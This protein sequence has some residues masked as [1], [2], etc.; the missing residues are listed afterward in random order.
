M[1]GKSI[2]NITTKCSFKLED[3]LGGSENDSLGVRY[4]TAY[5]FLLK[6]TPRAGAGLVT[7]QWQHGNTG[8]FI[9]ILPTIAA[10]AAQY[11]QYGLQY[12]LPATA[13]VAY[14]T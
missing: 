10:S 3:T 7:R 14:S 4:P 9:T 8:S 11:Y 13:G 12:Q 6:K 1:N 2:S 5:E